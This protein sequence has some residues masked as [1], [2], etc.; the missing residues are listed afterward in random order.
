MLPTD[1]LDRD[2][3]APMVSRRRLLASMGIGAFGLSMGIPTAE[4]RAPEVEVSA[5]GRRAR[6]ALRR[7]ALDDDAVDDLLADLDRRGWRRANGDTVVLR[8]EGPD[9]DPYHVVAL[10]LERPNEAG[11]AVVLWTDDG[12]FP[13]QAREFIPID[14]PTPPIGRPRPFAPIQ[15]SIEMRATVVDG[16]DLTMETIT[17]E[18]EFWWYFCSDLNWSCVLAIAGA[19][20]S[21]IASC[22]ACVADPSKITCLSCIGAVLTAA[23]TTL[24]CDWCEG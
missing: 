14:D 6:S 4:G 8:S 9:F 7:Q 21:A 13:A 22:A 5:P 2:R 20:A 10:S 18:P 17:F 3:T 15:P 1:P 12:P 16:G 24:G 11:Q 19:W 23:G